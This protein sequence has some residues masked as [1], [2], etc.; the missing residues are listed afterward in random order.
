MEKILEKVIVFRDRK[1]REIH[2]FVTM[3]GHGARIDLKEFLSLLSEEYGSPAST[4]R[5]KSHEKR[6]KD[7][8]NQVLRGMKIKTAAIAGVKFP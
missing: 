4:M 6:L 3:E 2:T 5:K 1:S 8:A 7:A